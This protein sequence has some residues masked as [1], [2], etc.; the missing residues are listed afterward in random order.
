MSLKSIQA[1]IT[2][3]LM[4]GVATPVYATA[5]AAAMDLRACVEQSIVLV[6]GERR[7]IG[8]GVAVNIG[9]RSLVA[10][11]ASRSG[12]ANKFGVR[13]FNGIG[14]IDSDYQGEIGVILENRGTADFE[15]NHGD[16]IAQLM[17]QPVV[18]VALEFVD[19]FE[20]PTARGEGGY[21]HTGV[22]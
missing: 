12:L 8:T 9:D 7:L 19:S 21:G 20:A 15:V 17:F 4:V 5:G 3:P 22:N 18:Q 14:V 11:V 2:N 10:L 6:P 16:R 13:V 1:R